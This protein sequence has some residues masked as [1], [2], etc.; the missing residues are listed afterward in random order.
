MI[1]I[2]SH[3]LLLYSALDFPIHTL[4][5]L[6]SLTLASQLTLSGFSSNTVFS[7]PLSFPT[8]SRTC[9]ENARGQGHAR[10]FHETIRLKGPTT[11]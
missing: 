10:P 4:R 9:P 1:T 8:L 7:I 2:S 3:V 11:H 5:L 6:H